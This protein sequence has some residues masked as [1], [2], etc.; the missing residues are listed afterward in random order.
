MNNSDDEFLVFK[1]KIKNKTVKC[2]EIIEENISK[3]IN[4]FS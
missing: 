2:H 1:K 3:V 4:F